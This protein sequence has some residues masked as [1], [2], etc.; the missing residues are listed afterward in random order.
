MGPSGDGPHTNSHN[1]DRRTPSLSIFS[2]EQ[3]LENQLKPLPLS[4]LLKQNKEEAELA[5][6]SGVAGQASQS[7]HKEALLGPAFS[8]QRGQSKVCFLASLAEVCS[9]RPGAAAA[10]GAE[11]AL[12]AFA[13]E[14]FGRKVRLKEP[15]GSGGR[16]A[17]GA[18]S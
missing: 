2:L 7:H 17:T 12:E 11:R 18:G 4:G 15:H 6:F 1:G 16:G 9:P 13:P 8:S 14:Q 5:H 3:L 10:E